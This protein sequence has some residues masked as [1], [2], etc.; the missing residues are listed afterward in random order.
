MSLTIFVAGAAGVIGRRLVP[1]LIERGY[2]VHGTTRSQSRA[3]DLERSGARPIV[4]DAFDRGAVLSAVAAV[5][6]HVLIHQLTDLSGGFEPEKVAET[7]ARNSRLRTE[8]TQNL[9]EAARAAGVRR[10]IAQSIVWVYAPGR[11]PHA[12][13]DPLDR[14]A[15]GTRAVTVQ[16]VL[17]LEEA[18][19]GAA[20]G[21]AWIEGLVL[22]YG[23]LYGP[24]ASE[25]PAGAPPLH[26]DAAAGAALLAIERGSP[27]VYNV[28]E[29]GPTTDVD[30]ARRELGWDPTFRLRQ[31]PC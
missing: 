24:G 22:R 1:L 7:L 12:E 18:V 26:V 16:G 27:G 28:A 3:S 11:E 17:A 23:W 5:R 8:G 4:L 19:L 13:G 6:P 29:P 31:S 10:L 20:S 30:K 15:E 25:K 21:A 2:E 14:A 9:V